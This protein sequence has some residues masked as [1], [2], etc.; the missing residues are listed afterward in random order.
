[1]VEVQ[2]TELTAEAGRCMIR[3]VRQTFK[4]LASTKLQCRLLIDTVKYNQSIKTIMN[5]NY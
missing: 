4:G 5:C 1:M 2:L 3:G